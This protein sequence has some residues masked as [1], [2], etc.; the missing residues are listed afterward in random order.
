[1]KEMQIHLVDEGYKLTCGA[2]EPTVALTELFTHENG[3]ACFQ[4]L[5][6]NGIPKKGIFPATG[7]PWRP[8]AL[9]YRPGSKA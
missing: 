7:W 1:M 6:G 2:P 5:L 8:A 3:R 9:A 4:V